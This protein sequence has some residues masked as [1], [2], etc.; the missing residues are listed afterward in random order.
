MGVRMERPTCATCPYYD[1]E[2][3]TC[4]RNP[5]VAIFAIIKETD[6]SGGDRGWGE[7]DGSG[8]VFPAMDDDEW[9]GEHPDFPA[10]I[11]SPKGIEPPPDS[12]VEDD[13]DRFRDELGCR[14]RKVI[15]K[16]GVKTMTELAALPRWK[17]LETRG[18]GI[19][20]VHK[21]DQFL[22]KN[23]HQTRWFTRSRSGT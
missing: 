21:I 8:S 15:S 20:T 2:E 9:C 16:L 11:A 12:P 19:T 5:P 14:E 22:A 18:C 7:L 10:Y 4:H 6:G 3:S 1:D 23:G 13:R 17:L